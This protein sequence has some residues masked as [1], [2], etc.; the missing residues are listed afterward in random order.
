MVQNAQIMTHRKENQTAMSAWSAT[1]SA[2][3]SD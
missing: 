2:D 1:V 3:Y